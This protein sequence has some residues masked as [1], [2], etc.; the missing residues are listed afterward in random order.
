MSILYVSIFDS[1]LIYMVAT[2][3]IY[4][5]IELYKKKIHVWVNL[6]SSFLLKNN[7]YRKQLWCAKYVLRH[8]NLFKEMLNTN[9]DSLSKRLNMARRKI[10]V[11]IFC[12]FDF[13]TDGRNLDETY[14]DRDL[15]GNKNIP[16]HHER[17]LKKIKNRG[18]TR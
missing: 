17:K 9:K 5:S 2:L 10:Q 8:F 4:V 1:I 12:S 18:I 6:N 3:I 11:I 13:T 7:V 14:V 15:I 16:F